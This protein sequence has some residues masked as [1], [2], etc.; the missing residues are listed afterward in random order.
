[1]TVTISKPADLSGVALACETLCGDVHSWAETVEHIAAFL[2]ATWQDAL[3]ANKYR[4][5]LTPDKRK[6]WAR[7]QYLTYLLEDIAAN[8]PMKARRHG[9]QPMAYAVR[10]RRAGND[11][12]PLRCSQ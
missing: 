6:R 3:E 11:S 7:V 12:R 9:R 2:E 5:T 4:A 1:M 10:S 8:L